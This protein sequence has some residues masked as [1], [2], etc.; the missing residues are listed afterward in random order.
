MS[1]RRPWGAA[2][3]AG[4]I[5]DRGFL[6]GHDTP[7]SD[8]RRREL[9]TVAE[10][11]GRCIVACDLALGGR[12]LPAAERASRLPVARRPLDQSAVAQRMDVPVAMGDVSAALVEYEAL[13][14]R[15]RD[16]LGL[17]PGPEIR[18][19][20]PAAPRR[21]VTGGQP[22]GTRQLGGRFPRNAAIPSCASSP[23]RPRQVSSV[24]CS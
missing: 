1:G 4:T 5:A 19:A 20:P 10:R 2:R 17:S 14:Q 12:E 9:A 13:R 18:A 11:A 15:L 7:W 8:E 22:S 16:E 23:A 6:I 24:A 3:V 21:R